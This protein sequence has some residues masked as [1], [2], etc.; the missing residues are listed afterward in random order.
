MSSLKYDCASGNQSDE[1]KAGQPQQDYTQGMSQYYLF[2]FKLQCN[3]GKSTF[4]LIDLSFG[5]KR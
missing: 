3:G 4:L 5:G 2:I 1:S